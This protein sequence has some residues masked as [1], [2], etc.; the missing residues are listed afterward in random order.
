M[1]LLAH[2]K[3]QVAALGATHP[4]AVGENAGATGVEIRPARHEIEHAGAVFDELS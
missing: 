3:R 2:Q 1:K 4:V